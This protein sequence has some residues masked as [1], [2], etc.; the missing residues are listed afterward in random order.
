M[1]EPDPSAAPSSS[2]EPPPTP[3]PA[4]TLLLLREGG[5]DGA[6]PR[7]LMGRRG[8]GAAFMPRALVFPGGA[9]EAGDAAYARLFDAAALAPLCRTRLAARSQDPSLALA[10]AAIRETFEETG[11][12]L[13]APETPPP[14]PEG[15]GPAWAR[16]VAGPAR[17]RLEALRFFMRAITPPGRPRRYDAR[18]FI[19][20]ADTLLGDPDDLSGGDGELSDLA[21]L[22][23][24]A[25]RAEKTPFVTKAALSD[26][27]QA[28]DGRAVRA[29]FEAP[30]ERRVLFYD[31]LDGELRERTL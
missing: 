5:E 17:P 3:A 29:L 9:L 15:S 27:T 13:A 20:D 26:L 10:A 2:A 19:A 1:S 7:V 18:F 28:L 22:P 30:F 23:L 16:F 21:W 25:A 24:S 4:A 8:R 14:P 12:R 31:G 11:L 6:G